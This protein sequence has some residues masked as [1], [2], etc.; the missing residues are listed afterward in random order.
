MRDLKVVR[1]RRRHHDLLAATLL[2]VFVSVSLGLT[3]SGSAEAWYGGGTPPHPYPLSITDD[4]VASLVGN[5]WV[6]P[7]VSANADLIVGQTLGTAGG[8]YLDWR[9]QVVPVQNLYGFGVTDP[10][11]IA[12]KTSIVLLG[13]N[14]PNETTGSIALE[15]MIDFLVG[16]DPRMAALR[17]HAEF[18]VYPQSNPEGRVHEYA[19]ANPENPSKDHN[20][21]W[22]DTTGLMTDVTIIKTSMWTDTGG[23]VDYFFDFHSIG[24]TGSGA[25]LWTKSHLIHSDFA[26]YLK[27]RE[28]G[29]VRVATSGV[30][31]MARIWAM[32]SDGL[33]A[34]FSFTPEFG[35]NK[36]SE[37]YITYGENY[38]LALYDTIVPEPGDAN[39][40]Y[41]IDGVDL[42]IWQTNYDPL[43]LNANAFDMGDWNYDGLI[44]GGDLALWQQNYAP[45][46]YLGL[47]E[48]TPEPGT[49]LLLGTGLLCITRMTADGPTAPRRQ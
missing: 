9:A 28:S 34:E 12:S 10:A 15:G 30:S 36:T 6:S 44:N 7:T 11:G 35:V 33:N 21:Y 46:G 16:D 37:R 20:R 23:D 4:Q 38:A 1:W 18:Y 27:D 13:G 47:L 48:T 3:V 29:I 40:D 25:Q 31:G 24:T 2:T 17:H 39:A 5:P 14:H 42:G 8:G 45:L 19:R 41:M 26:D 49:L 43:G 32:S 22:N